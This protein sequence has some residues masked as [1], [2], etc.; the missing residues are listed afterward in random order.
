M[1][2][3]VYTSLVDHNLRA[4]HAL[5]SPATD[6][7][8]KMYK[9][10]MSGKSSRSSTMFEK[11]S[12]NILI[13]TIKNDKIREACSGLCE[14]IDS[15]MTARSCVDTCE[16]NNLSKANEHSS[17]GG[18]CFERTYYNRGSKNT[19]QRQVSS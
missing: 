18:N 1:L 6:I 13:H 17:K 3:I 10:T 5:E 16:N 4:L 11:M 7:P 15:I 2:R 19:C 8:S 14:M 9:W 12:E